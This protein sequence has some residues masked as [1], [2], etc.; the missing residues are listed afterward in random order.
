MKRLNTVLLATALMGTLAIA[1]SAANCPSS[2]GTCKK[3]QSNC[4]SMSSGG[5][6]QKVPTTGTST[7]RKT[8]GRTAKARK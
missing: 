1:A 5:K 3:G 7:A 4:S 8:A 6:C 2:G